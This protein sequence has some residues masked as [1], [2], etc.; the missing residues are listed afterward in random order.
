MIGGISV[1]REEYQK[2]L[3]RVD[4]YGKGLTDWE[5]NFVADLIDNP[6][7]HPSEKQI[8]ILKRIDKEKVR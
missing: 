1:I 6:P 7:A 3:E 4:K 5:I 8:S 2:L